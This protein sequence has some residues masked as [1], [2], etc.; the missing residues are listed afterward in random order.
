LAHLNAFCRGVRAVAIDRPMITR[1]VQHR[2]R[3]ELAAADAVVLPAVLDYHRDVPARRPLP[4]V[5][6]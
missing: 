4:A 6:P 3:Q 5:R 1:Y 2:Q